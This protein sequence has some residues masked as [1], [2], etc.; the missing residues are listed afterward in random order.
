MKY[1][2]AFACVCVE[3]SS[4][5]PDV[6]TK[7]SRADYVNAI[8]QLAESAMTELKITDET[9]DLDELLTDWC[10]KNDFEYLFH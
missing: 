5:I 2:Y 10:A 6:S 7:Y 1:P 8:L 4:K 3:L 9:T